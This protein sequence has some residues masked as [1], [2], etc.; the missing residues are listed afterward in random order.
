MRRFGRVEVTKRIWGILLSGLIVPWLVMA[1]DRASME[2]PL[3]RT[4]PD[5]V[6]FIALFSAF[7]PGG[8]YR[9]GVGT[10][11]ADLSSAT[12]E[13]LRDGTPV[14]VKIVNFTQGYTSAW[15]GVEQIRVRGC[16]LKRSQL[17][18]NGGSLTLKFSIP[19]ADAGKAGKLYVFVA[20]K[21]GPTT[22]YVEDGAELN[23]RHW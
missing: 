22:W 7:V 17:P 5:T 10:N 13:L 20:K 3:I 8:Y 16:V 19:R 6:S 23:R 15:W 11:G 18:G 4:T 12:I 9:L 2:A 14:Q 21:Y 1:Q